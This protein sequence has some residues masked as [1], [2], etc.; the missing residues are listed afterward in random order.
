MDNR[1]K[2]IIVKIMQ[3]KITEEELKDEMS[4][5]EDLKFDSIAFV[6]MVVMLES[7][8]GFSFDDEYISFEMLKTVKDVAN[9]VK[10]KTA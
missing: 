7:T 5:T 2:T 9:Y 1:Y 8:Y 3:N 4:L 10:L 6:N